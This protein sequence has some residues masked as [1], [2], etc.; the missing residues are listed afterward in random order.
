MRTRLEH[1][2]ATVESKVLRN[3]DVRTVQKYLRSR[4]VNI[5]NEPRKRGLLDDSGLAWRLDD[6]FA[7]DHDFALDYYR[8]RI[9]HEHGVRPVIS[10]LSRS[11]L[12]AMG[13]R[14]KARIQ[15]GKKPRIQRREE[16]GIERGY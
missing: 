6:D 16:T 2:T 13:N 4:R 8:P 11:P 1:G 5:K 10:P 14:P 3:A 9:R 7:L 12:L 15:R